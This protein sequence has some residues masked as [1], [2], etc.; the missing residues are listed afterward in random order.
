MATDNPTPARWS[1]PLNLDQGVGL[2]FL[3][4]LTEELER[5]AVLDKPLLQAVEEFVKPMTNRPEYTSLGDVWSTKEH[6]GHATAFVSYAYEGEYSVG[7]MLECMAE[8]VAHHRTEQLWW[9]IVAV[10]KHNLKQNHRW[11]VCPRFS[12]WQKLLTG[13]IESLPTFVLVLSSWRKPMEL[14]RLWVLYELWCAIRARRKIVVLVADRKGVPQ[15][16]EAAV[17][18]E[19]KDRV[20]IARASCRNTAH[21]TDHDLR[22]VFAQYGEKQVED[23]IVVALLEAVSLAMAACDTVYAPMPELVDPK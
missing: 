15:T 2:P 3:T 9:S 1:V 10:D 21:Y 12:T 7:Q 8:Y 18:T 4:S 14:S 22:K 5:H 19:I 16:D 23:A 13:V 11:P 6:L 20:N 17:H